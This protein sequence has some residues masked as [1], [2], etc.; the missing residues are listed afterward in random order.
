MEKFFYSLSEYF[1]NADTD[2]LEFWIYPL[3]TI[4]LIYLS[5]IVGLKLIKPKKLKTTFLIH[6]IWI[7]SSLIIATIVIS[8]ICSYWVTNYFSK[9]HV[10]LALLISLFASLLIPIFRFVSLRNYFTN[11]GL[12]EIA[13]QPKTPSTLEATIVFARK[14][15]NRIKIFY[16]IP[17]IGFLFLLGLLNKGQNLIAIIFDNSGSMEYKNASDALSETF[18]HLDYNNEII[19]STLDGLGENLLGSQNSLNNIL[20]KNIYTQLNGGN[21]AYFAD[22]ISAKNGLHQIANECWGSPICEA[23]WKSFL[24]VKATQDINNYKNRLLIII[25]DGD[26]NIQN[27]IQSSKFFYDDNIFMQYFPPDNTLIIDYSDGMLNPLFNRFQESG[28]EI[29]AV[30]DIKQ[31]YLDALDVALGSFKNNWNLIFWT[32]TIC[33]LLTTIALFVETKKIV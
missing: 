19:F 27:T 14:C 4:L 26:D 10:E 29:Y 21:V 8:L 17:I 24:F 25:S 32:I 23:I 18:D 2:K 6:K 33:V 1:R 13:Y 9:N 28:C 12:K 15:F 30:E 31:D 16:L 22:P 11:E 3:A 20:S 5:T 7:V